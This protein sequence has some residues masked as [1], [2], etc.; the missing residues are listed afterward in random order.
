MILGS[1]WKSTIKKRGASFPSS[2]DDINSSISTLA[3]EIMGSL[4]NIICDQRH[5]SCNPA[6]KLTRRVVNHVQRRQSPVISRDME[7]LKNRQ[8]ELG[9]ADS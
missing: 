9:L 4:G 2:A 5:N 1:F 6:E 3:E 8:A 7:Y